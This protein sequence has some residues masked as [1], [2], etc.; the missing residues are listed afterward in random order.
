LAILIRNCKHIK[1]IVIDGEEYII[2]Q[3]AD[4]TSFILDGSPISLAKT[5]EMLDFYADISG[6][7]DI[8]TRSWI[9]ASKNIMFIS[10][11]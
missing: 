3:Y 9:Y 8:Y 4:D 6:L 1:G 10:G 5:L 2:S 11:I 7:V